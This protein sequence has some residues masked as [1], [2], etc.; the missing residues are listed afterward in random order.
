M[1]KFTVHPSDYLQILSQAQ[2]L[3]NQY[4]SKGH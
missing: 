2:D 4:L 3:A 1:D